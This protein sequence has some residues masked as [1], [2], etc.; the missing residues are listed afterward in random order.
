MTVRFFLAILLTLASSWAQ[1]GA[2]QTKEVVVIGTIH[3]DHNRFPLYTFNTLEIILKHIAPDLILI[4]EDPRT[5]DQVQKLS[6]EE[7][8]KIRPVEIKK[9]ILPF[10]SAKNIKV[11]PTDW[12]IEFDKDSEKQDGEFKTLLKDENNRKQFATIEAYD[13]LFVDDYLT[14]SV[15]DLHSD[16]F[17]SILEQRDLLFD[18]TVFAK[19]RE[20]DRLRQSKINENV[21]SFLK[22]ESFKKAVVI[23]G[24]SHRPFIIRAIKKS[25]VANVLGLRESMQSRLP[26]FFDRE[27]PL[28]M[29]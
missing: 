5:F 4:E 20:L 21:I 24:I 16:T 29:P 2:A 7:Y 12:R 11:I 28:T 26:S 25:G 9:V 22:K 8:G 14:K 27:K 6:E 10:A 18:R 19:S 23:Y 1:A 17:M 15:Y 13:S 3:G